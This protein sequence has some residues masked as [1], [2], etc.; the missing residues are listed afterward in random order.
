MRGNKK[1]PE[2]MNGYQAGYAAAKKTTSNNKACWILKN[3][4][5]STTN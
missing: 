4:K 2:Y 5:W 1:S 3:K